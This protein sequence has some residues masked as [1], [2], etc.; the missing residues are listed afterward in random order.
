MYDCDKNK[1]ITHFGK[2]VYEVFEAMRTFDFPFLY[3]FLSSFDSVVHTTDHIDNYRNCATGQPYWA[4][5]AC[6]EGSSSGCCQWGHFG[7]SD[8]AVVYYLPTV[9][10]DV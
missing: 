3:S 5:S 9:T 1:V 7:L 4:A 8:D 2:L 6:L 10:C